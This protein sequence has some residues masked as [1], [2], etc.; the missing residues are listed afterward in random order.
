MGRQA[1]AILCVQS[2]NERSIVEED[3]P[4]SVRIGKETVKD[5]DREAN[6]G[7]IHERF[8]Y[9]TCFEEKECRALFL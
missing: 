9:E 6:A 3:G 2:N 8:V 1:L 4:G 5:L 7:Y